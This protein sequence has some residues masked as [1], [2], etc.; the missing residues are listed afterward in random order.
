MLH[1][2]IVAGL[3]IAAAL[4][5]PMRAEATDLLEMMTHSKRVTE[6]AAAK[7]RATPRTER[8][9]C[10]DALPQF[11]DGCDKKFEAEDA[12]RASGFYQDPSAQ[13][14]CPPPARMTDDGCQPPARRR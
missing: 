1:K 2:K 3:I 4:N 10:Y 12:R 14:L 13:S 8:Q 6:E 11:R 7:E 5:F 9:R